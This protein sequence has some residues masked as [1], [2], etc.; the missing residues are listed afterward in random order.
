V[1]RALHVPAKH[2][3]AKR[4]GFFGEGEADKFCNWGSDLL[5]I[6]MFV[7]GKGGGGVGEKGFSTCGIF[8]QSLREEIWGVLWGGKKRMLE[9]SCDS[10]LRCGQKIE[11]TKA[12]PDETIYVRNRKEK[13]ADHHLTICSRPGHFDRQNITEEK[14]KNNRFFVPLP[15]GVGRCAHRD[16][17]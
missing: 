17:V 11:L 12:H 1:A 14:K 5:M 9:H 2:V 4:K 8:F 3:C 10:S 16:H 6:T 15:A 13:R 7:W